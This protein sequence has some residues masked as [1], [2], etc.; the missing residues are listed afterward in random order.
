[1]FAEERRNEITN[2]LKSEGRVS[3]NGLAEKFQVSID[4]IRRDLSIMEDKGLL[5]RTH[6]GAIPAPKVRARPQRSSVREVETNIHPNVA[7]I[8]KHAASLIDEGDTVFI[9]GSS[10]HYVML[11][12]LPAEITFTVVTSSIIVADELRSHD[13]IETF[14][15]C[16]KIRPNGD[17]VDALASDFVKTLRIDKAF[18]VSG[19]L[20]AE[21]GLSNATSETVVFHRSVASVSRKKICLSPNNKL[22]TEFFI[23]EIPAEDLDMVITDWDA[24]EDE[25]EKLRQIGVE[26]IV[27]EKGF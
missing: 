26:V 3:V 21:H 14:L 9:G 17:L 15:V 4:T 1:M 27:A 22:G 20:S 2:I 8:A 18:M 13:N 10:A 19:G 16:G 25:I 7:A 23:R 11:R 5:K 12:Y 24:P 6:G